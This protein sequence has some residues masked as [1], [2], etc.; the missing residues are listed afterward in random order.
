MIIKSGANTIEKNDRNTKFHQRN[1][2]FL[3]LPHLTIDN[4]NLTASRESNFSDR[5]VSVS[6]IPKYNLLSP[7]MGVKKINPYGM[8]MNTSMNMYSP[9]VNA[10]RKYKKFSLNKTPMPKSKVYS[11]MDGPPDPENIFQSTYGPRSS[12]DRGSCKSMKPSDNTKMQKMEQ[13]LIK[14]RIELTKVKRER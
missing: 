6:G 2:T 13:V 12:I 7:Q 3:N 11:R 8:M 1:D 9:N 4:Y 14:K 5:I 10:S